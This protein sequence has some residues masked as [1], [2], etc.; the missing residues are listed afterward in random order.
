MSVTDWGKVREEGGQERACA[1]AVREEGTG[2]AD[3]QRVPC[4]HSWMTSSRTQFASKYVAVEEIPA[5]LLPC[6]A[7]SGRAERNPKCLI[8]NGFC[9]NDDDNKKAQPKTALTYSLLHV[10]PDLSVS[11]PNTPQS[12]GSSHSECTFRAQRPLITSKRQ[13]QLP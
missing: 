10:V 1:S 4:K 9:R 7:K 12:Q 13:P 5:R 6:L 11:C 8:Q 2:N 3:Q